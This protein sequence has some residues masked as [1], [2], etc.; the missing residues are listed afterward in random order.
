MIALVETYRS[1]LSGFDPV[2]TGTTGQRVADETGLAVEREV[3]SSAEY[4]LEGL[5][6]DERGVRNT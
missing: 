4:L 1:V 2:A 3:R 5:A 6:A